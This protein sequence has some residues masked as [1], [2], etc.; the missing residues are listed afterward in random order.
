M[1]TELT[2]DSKYCFWI[3]DFNFRLERNF[4]NYY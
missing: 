4:L 3:G 1:G 2:W